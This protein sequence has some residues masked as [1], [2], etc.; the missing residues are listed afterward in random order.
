MDLIRLVEDNSTTS[1]KDGVVMHVALSKSLFQCHL[2]E[3]VEMS[4][5]FFEEESKSS[6]AM[7]DW[8]T[9]YG[10]VGLRLGLFIE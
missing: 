8:S 4:T 7:E 3:Q 6:T 9:N 2:V 5:G 10:R 1:V